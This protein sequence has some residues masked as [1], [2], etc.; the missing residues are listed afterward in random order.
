MKQ[1][2]Q[3]LGWLQKPAQTEPNPMRTSGRGGGAGGCKD[4]WKS[5]GEGG[6]GKEGRRRGTGAWRARGSRPGNQTHRALGCALVG[7]GRKVNDTVNRPLPYNVLAFFAHTYTH[8][9]RTHLRVLDA[10][11][12]Q[13]RR[14]A[15]AAGVV[16]RGWGSSFRG[17]RGHEGG[18]TTQGSDMKSR[19]AQLHMTIVQSLSSACA[20]NQVRPR[21]R[22]PL[23]LGSRP[24]QGRLCMFW[25]ARAR[26]ARARLAG[27]HV[28]DTARPRAPTHNTGWLRSAATLPLMSKLGG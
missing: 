24:S 19:T 6:G 11:L 8:N 27:V 18:T 16:G 26:R 13:C 1:S 2:L 15:A 22:G 12:Q 23:P 5:G 17:Q 28:R 10:L 9:M 7:E 25:H 20:S 4:G 21:D 3:G 14:V